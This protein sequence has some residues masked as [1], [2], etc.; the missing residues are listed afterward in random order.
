MLMRVIWI[1][2]MKT[3]LDSL[4]RNILYKKGYKRDARMGRDF[5]LG[6]KVPV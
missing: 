3:L 2:K 5:C 1:Q 4:T 6:R